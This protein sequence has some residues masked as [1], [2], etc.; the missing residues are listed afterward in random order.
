VILRY[1]Q[2]G[3]SYVILLGL[4]PGIFLLFL[5]KATRE[6]IGMGDG[7]MMLVLGIYLGVRKVLDLFFLSLFLSSIW[8]GFLLLVKKKRRDWEF[9]FVPFLFLGYV[10]MCVLQL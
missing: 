7:V 5:S 4:L 10:G 1:V 2:G 9:P 8:A 6:S 3:E